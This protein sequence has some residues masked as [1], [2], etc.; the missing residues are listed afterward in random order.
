LRTPQ[1][2]EFTLDQ[3]DQNVSPAIDP[4]TEWIVLSREGLGKYF[5]VRKGFCDDVSKFRKRILDISQGH[6]IF[7]V[8]LNGNLH[9]LKFE[10]R[11]VLFPKDALP[12]IAVELS[13]RIKSE[14]EQLPHEQYKKADRFKE[15]LLTDEKIEAYFT[16]LI[17]KDA[18]RS[19]Y[20]EKLGMI[21]NPLFIILMIPKLQ[22]Y[23]CF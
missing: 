5:A 14:R 16:Y 22:I 18:L 23:L 19:L 12:D 11:S 20:R 1:L 4:K 15:V 6:K 2:G 7:S 9:I 8:T 3:I 17:A 21:M 10:K 13:L